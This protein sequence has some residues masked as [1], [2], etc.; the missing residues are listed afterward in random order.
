M[1]NESMVEDQN[2]YAFQGEKE[3]KFPIEFDSHDPFT[4]EEIKEKHKF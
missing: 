3:K 2:Q 4:G 1:D